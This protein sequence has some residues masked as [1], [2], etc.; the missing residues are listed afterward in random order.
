MPDLLREAE[1]LR[2]AGENA[3]AEGTFRQAIESDPRSEQSWADFGCLMA[4]GHRYTEAN[5]AFRHATELLKQDP[6]AEVAGDEL[7]GTVQL[8]ARLTTL[9]PDWARGQFS[10]ACACEQVRDFDRARTH[11]ENAIRLEPALEVAAY[12][13]QASMYWMEEKWAEA[14]DAADRAIAAN[15]HY[16]FAHLIR[17]RCCLCLG[18][19]TDACESFRRAI[20]IQPHPEPHSALLFQMNN[21]PSTT[22]E[23]LYAEA[24]RWNSLYA[25]PLA[26]QIRPHD[27][28]PDPERRLRIGYVSPDLYN[29]AIM[30]FVPPVFERH[31]K[32]CFDVRIY[33]IGPTSDEIT[34]QLRARVDH[35][36]AIRETHEELAARV[37]RDQIDILVDLAGHT[38]GPPYLAFALKP[39]PIQVT[40]LGSLS[41]TGMTAIDYFL[42]DAHM[43]C[44]G[45]DHLF[46][47]TVYR[48]PRSVCCYRPFAD[49]PVTAPP[50]LT[51]GYVTFGSFNSFR[52]IHRDLVKL[53][54]AILHLVPQSKLLLKYYGM[55]NEEIQGRLRDWFGQDGIAGERLLFEGP[56]KMTKYLESYG[57]VDIALDP[58]PYN[59]GSTTLDTL[60]MGVPVVTLAGRLAVQSGGASLLAAVGLSDYVARTPEEYL[61]TA[62]FLAG[63]VTKMPAS[64]RHLR[65]ALKRSPLMDEAGFVRDLEDAYRTM[66]RAWCA[67]QTGRADRK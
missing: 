19:M 9:K 45:T 5:E 15:P 62:I 23:S 63:T 49:V 56:E 25:D 10:L 60:W 37:R 18:R 47:E 8:L 6:Q 1:L 64:R 22:P 35:Y 27:N 67:K 51:K 48:L 4:D 54:A 28:T 20:A 41:T 12:S 44:P 55:E 16:F 13:L 50:Y 29:H 24:W 33:A 66:W 36:I 57:K 2:R 3:R 17:A 52:K 53:W 42:G 58:F 38:M 30:K 39:A 59:G 65:E 7:H 40:W 31:D 61:K 21:L 43:P 46:T 26:P 11:I 34:A 14:I 32:S